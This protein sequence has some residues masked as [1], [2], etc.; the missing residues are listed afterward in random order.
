MTRKFPPKVRNGLSS[1]LR[2][3][4]TVE[5]NRNNKHTH[6]NRE[7]FENDFLTARTPFSLLNNIF[8]RFCNKRLT[9]KF[10][11]NFAQK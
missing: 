7:H 11:H 5:T 10:T 6:V 3:H 8:V 4:K 9:P 1:C 2:I